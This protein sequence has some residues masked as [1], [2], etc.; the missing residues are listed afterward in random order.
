MTNGATRSMKERHL[1]SAN[2][3]TMRQWMSS[4]LICTDCGYGTL[5]DELICNHIVVRMKD[6]EVSEKLQMKLTLDNAMMMRQSE[7]IKTQQPVVRGE[8]T[9]NTV[10]LEAIGAT[11]KCTCAPAKHK[12]GNATTRSALRPQKCGKSP[13]HGCQQCPANNVVC[14][15]C[16]K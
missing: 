14:H 11:S 4:L 13:S 16:H 2:K 8:P 15:R 12:V 7:A 1:I 6:R 5:S 3:R 10:A 9:K